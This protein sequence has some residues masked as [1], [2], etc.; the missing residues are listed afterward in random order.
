M[1]TPADTSNA[2]STADLTEKI[3]SDPPAGISEDQALQLAGADGAA[4]MDLIWAADRVRRHFKGN[5]I[6]TC[7]IINAK[8][9]KCSQDC[10]FCAQSGHH[11]TGVD[12]YPLMSEKEMITRA[13]EMEDA[14]MTHFSMVTSGLFL[15]DQ[16]IDTI[17]RAAETI[18]SRTHLTLCGSLGMLT[19]KQ[20]QLLRQS[21]IRNYHHN[22]E[23]A[24]S[25][26][27][28]VCTT[29]EYDAD[30]ESIRAAA[31]TGL[32]VCAGGIM[33]LGET[34]AQRIELAVTLR[35]IGVEKIPLNFINPIA[36]TRMADQ[37]LLSVAE[38]LKTIAL[39]R[40]INPEKDITICGGRHVTLGDFQSWIF[41][42]GANG[43]MTGNYLTTTG[44]D[45]AQDVKMIH[46]WQQ[47]QG[48]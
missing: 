47:M 27:R 34:R 5:E 39:F 4:F 16:E 3:L 22:L 37:P 6:F 38:A 13:L 19:Q 48:Q 21:G 41:A 43:I 11:D 20:A 42:A 33:G 40:L 2:C 44:R 15:S 31:N 32:A 23:T 10:A 26:F 12:T 36:G 45:I 18:G 29:H 24:R 30:I 9:G 14:Q 17:C 35:E 46:Q 1:K 8:S 28:Q 25:H 7:S